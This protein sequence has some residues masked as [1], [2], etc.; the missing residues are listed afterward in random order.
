M[1]EGVKPEKIQ[2]EMDLA[3]AN[4]LKHP[5]SEPKGIDDRKDT[6]ERVCSRKKTQ[7]QTTN[8]TMRQDKYQKTAVSLEK[9]AI[10]HM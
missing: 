7:C 10:T 4:S 1:D 6:R 5:N 2:K 9:Q 8:I 3:K